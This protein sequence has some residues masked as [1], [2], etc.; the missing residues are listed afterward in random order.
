[1]LHLV[2]AI[3]DINGYCDKLKVPYISLSADKSPSDYE[4]ALQCIWRELSVV[5]LYCSCIP[6]GIFAHLGTVP[7]L[8]SLLTSCDEMSDMSTSG[9][10]TSI[11]LQRLAGKYKLNPVIHSVLSFNTHN[12]LTEGR[13]VFVNSY[14]GAEGILK[15]NALVEHSVLTGQFSIGSG[16]VVSHVSESFGCELRIKSNVMIEIIP[17]YPSFINI[18]GGC[19][20]IDNAEVGNN[21]SFVST[22]AAVML[23]GISDDVK[24]HYLH[25]T[26]RVCG[27]LWSS[28]FNVSTYILHYI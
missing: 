22:C 19:L 26:A 14:I 10:R 24:L 18:Y 3:V 1:M 11:K 6:D 20:E 5:P 28:F 4:H 8:L 27:N 9:I 15:N 21:T 16:S 2:Q 13:S 12:N 17:L 23:I 25:P 7:E